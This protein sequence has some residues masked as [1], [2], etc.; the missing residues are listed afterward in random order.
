[1]IR[2][3]TTRPRK[4]RFPREAYVKRFKRNWQPVI[5]TQA[6]RI[7]TELYKRGVLADYHAWY[8]AKHP[9]ITSKADPLTDR[10]QL[11]IMAEM[12][13]AESQR[14]WTDSE[15]LAALIKE[16][17]IDVAKEAS[18][19]AFANMGVMTSW[20]MESPFIADLIKQRVNMT[21]TIT[22]D[23]V[24]SQVKSMLV[25]QFYDLGAGA[26]DT[27]FMARL[28]DVIPGSTDYIVERLARTE[29][30]TIQSQMQQ[31]TWESNNVTHKEWVHTGGIEPR[32]SHMAMSGEVVAIDK[33][34]SNGLMMPLDPAGGPEEICNCRCHHS[35]I[36]D[37]ELTD[38]LAAEGVVN[39]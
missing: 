12:L 31:K 15:V 36:V 10:Q 6:R 28:K 25:E 21:T 5:R 30:G 16:G 35:P 29:V 39:E 2:A 19:Y 38:Q 20:N 17:V 33:P 24:F 32:E 3:K 4:A 22:S 14:W 23:T 13:Q 8:S 27:S 11:D 34:F 9:R 18:K 26:V 1:V 7:V 37:D